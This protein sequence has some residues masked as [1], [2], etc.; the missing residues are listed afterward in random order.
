LFS[1]K[2]AGNEQ[3]TALTGVVLIVLL[4]VIGVTILRLRSLLWIHLF[5]GLLL[6]GPVALKLSSTGYRF[7]R[8]YSNNAHYRRKGPPET[9]L[10]MLA[11]IVVLSTIVVLASGVALLLVGPSS[12][13]TLLPIHK[14]SFIVWGV[15]TAIHVLGHLADLP[16]TLGARRRAH[17]WNTDAL[18]TTG[19]LLSL[20]GALVGGLTLAILLI[21]QFTPWLHAHFHHA[22]H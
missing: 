14:I 18:G 12:R 9:Y 4:A 13:A 11:P 8:Y 1:S 5:V 22:P 15:V 20:G 6:I 2:S 17:D 21:P 7:L 19:R 10:R 16:R 3:L